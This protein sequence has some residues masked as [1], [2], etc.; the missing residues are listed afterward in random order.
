MTSYG[1]KS[2]EKSVESTRISTSTS[3]ARF[4]VRGTRTGKISSV[5]TIVATALRSATQRNDAFCK[6]RL[7][8][9]KTPFKSCSSLRN[10]R[11]CAIREAIK[12]NEVM[13]CEDYKE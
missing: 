13:I 12:D 10:K 6:D 11:L 8:G 7:T 2:L 1:S 5:E 9:I 3:R 4:L